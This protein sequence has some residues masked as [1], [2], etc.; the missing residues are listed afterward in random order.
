MYLISYLKQY[1]FNRRS[2]PPGA[3]RT[4]G[5]LD[6]EQQAEVSFSVSVRNSGAPSTAAVRIQITDINDVP[7]RFHRHH[8]KVRHVLNVGSINIELFR[9]I[10]ITSPRTS[11]IRQHILSPRYKLH[12]GNGEV[13]SLNRLSGEIV[14]RHLL[15]GLKSEYELIITAFD[16]G[17][18]TGTGSHQTKK[19]RSIFSNHYILHI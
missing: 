2:S 19:L 10:E 17:E 6:H 3:I 8:N 1:F 5:P 15:E 9:L 14:L 16:G 11:T 12:C 7:P 4:V 13:F 18:A